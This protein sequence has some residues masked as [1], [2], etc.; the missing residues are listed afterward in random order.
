MHGLLVTNPADSRAIPRGTTG[1]VELRLIQSLRL[2]PDT[3]RVFLAGINFA[4][5]RMAVFLAV[6]GCRHSLRSHAGQR[7]GSILLV[8]PR[9][10]ALGV[11]QNA[12]PCGPLSVP[13]R[14]APAILPV[15]HHMV[16]A[17]G[18][19]EVSRL[20]RGGNQPVITARTA[21]RAKAGADNMR[22]S[23]S[24]D[25][26]RR[27]A[28]PWTVRRTWVHARFACASRAAGPFRRGGSPP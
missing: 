4:A 20:A 8:R 24:P 17:G 25:R 18:M 12:L 11:V 16:R 19:A 2:R 5:H 23:P 1:F 27:R 13:V 3:R 28:G 9:G 26:T 22:S 7:D 10:M 15:R 21:L 14:V 6:R